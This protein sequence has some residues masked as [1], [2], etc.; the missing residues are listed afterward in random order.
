MSNSFWIDFFKTARTF[1][2]H[3]FK[4]AFVV[5]IVLAIAISL[6]IF[7]NKNFEWEEWGSKGRISSGPSVH[8]ERR[9]SFN[10]ENKPL[11]SAVDYLNKKAL[12]VNIVVSPDLLDGSIKTKTISV[13]LE[14]A[15]LEDVL[16]AYCA[17]AEISSRLGWSRKGKNIYIKHVEETRE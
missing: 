15:T 8:D 5:V 11:I 4:H 6:A 16:N 7:F 1:I 13:H 9:F 2:K 10:F 14:D 17:N 3:Y 12:E